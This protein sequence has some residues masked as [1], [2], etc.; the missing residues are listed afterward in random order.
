MRGVKISDGTESGAHGGLEF[1]LADLLSALGSHG[2]ESRWTCTDLNYVS[3]DDRDVP[4]LE[5]S[6]AAGDQ[7]TGLELIDGVRDKAQVI[8][9]EF[10]GFDERGQCWIVLRA[11]DSSWWEVWS[12]QPWVHEVIRERFR[13]VESLGESAE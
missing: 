10:T 2:R 8:D 5:R 4:S 6:A 11:V 7:V 9:G 12:D 1:D 13:V 3:F